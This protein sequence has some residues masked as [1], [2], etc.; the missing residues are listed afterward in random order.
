MKSAIDSSFHKFLAFM[1]S[2]S[3]PSKAA[4]HML[5]NRV[6]TGEYLIELALE[7]RLSILMSISFNQLIGSGLLFLQNRLRNYILE[8][9]FSVL[10]RFLLGV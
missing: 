6:V 10:V 8:R 2:S 5:I 9:S 3:A 7:A 1:T 4:F